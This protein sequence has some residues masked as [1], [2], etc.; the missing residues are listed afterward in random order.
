[1]G[2]KRYNVKSSGTNSQVSLDG[3]YYYE[4]PSGS[5]YYK[6]G[7]VGSTYPALD[8]QSYSQGYGNSSQGSD[9]KQ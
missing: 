4:N 1:M 3:L 8:V 6:N 9:S 2:D 7:N 5:T